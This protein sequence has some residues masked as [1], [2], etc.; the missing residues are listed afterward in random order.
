MSKILTEIVLHHLL[1]N[2]FLRK[3]T[4]LIPV[5]L[6]SYLYTE[7]FISNLPQDNKFP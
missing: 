1:S 2:V 5:S 7:T 6:P 3:V 4:K